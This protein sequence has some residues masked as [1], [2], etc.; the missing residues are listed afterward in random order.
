MVR[1]RGDVDLAGA[2]ATEGWV[3][4]LVALDAIVGAMLL[5]AGIYLLDPGLADLG[6]YVEAPRYLLLGGVFVAAGLLLAQASIFGFVRRRTGALGDLIEGF[7]GRSSLWCLGALLTVL[8]VRAA[9][10]GDGSIAWLAALAVPGLLAFATLRVMGL[11]EVGVEAPVPALSADAGKRAKSKARDFFRSAVVAL[12]VIYFLT[13]IAI[14]SIFVYLLL[15]ISFIGGRAVNVAAAFETFAALYIKVSLALIPLGVGF[16]LIGALALAAWRFFRREA[17]SDFDR[18]LSAEETSFIAS[19]VRQME[20]YIAQHRLRALAEGARNAFFGWFWLFGA[21]AV[22]MALLIRDIV[23]SI[24]APTG[25][26]WRLYLTEGPGPMVAA[27][28]ALLSLIFLPGALARL[29]S[30]RA[31]EAGGL[32]TFGAHDGEAGLQATL[33][34][35]VRRRGLKPLDEFDPGSLLR[36]AG[37]STAGLALGWNAVVAIALLVWWPHDRARDTLYTEQWIET[38]DFWTMER[39]RFAYGSVVSVRLE[40]ANNVSYQIVLPNGA[41]REL[42]SGYAFSARLQDAAKIDDKL[43]SAG[44]RFGLVLPGE[45]PSDTAGVVDRECLEDLMD[46]LDPKARATAERVLHLDAWFERR[47]RKRTGELSVSRQ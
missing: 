16:A 28:V 37:R 31:A 29:L 19:C 1:P 22:V 7:F 13:T 8:A 35:L 26:G 5:V 15:D 34:G 18:D 6:L 38:G 40:C 23:A 14:G 42:L 27:L 47:W 43:R 24:H 44:V 20:S 21:S 41:R 3:R 2:R 10:S 33:V 45:A 30:V 46:G 39:E 36:G 11:V 12:F 25:E 32:S 4:V 17:R 9:V